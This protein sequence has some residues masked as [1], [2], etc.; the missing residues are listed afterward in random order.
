MSGD[1][2]LKFIGFIARLGEHECR[3]EPE[4]NLCNELSPE[5][6]AGLVAVIDPSDRI[7]IIGNKPAFTPYAPGI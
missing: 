2:A 1:E 5:R 6:R 4:F 7:G 3:L